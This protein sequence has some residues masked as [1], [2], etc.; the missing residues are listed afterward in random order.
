MQSFYFLTCYFSITEQPWGYLQ[1]STISENR[2][3]G[4]LGLVNCLS[5]H[6]I[7][8]HI[9][10]TY[11]IF[12]PVIP[13]W[14]T[15]SRKKLSLVLVA[16]PLW[17]FIVILSGYLVGMMDWE[18]YFYIIQVEQTCSETIWGGWWEGAEIGSIHSEANHVEENQTYH[19][20][21]WQVSILVKAL[22]LFL[23]LLPITCHFLQ[24]YYC[25]SSSWSSDNLLWA[26]W[27][28]K[29]LLWGTI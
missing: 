27:S 6:V 13:H 23:Y 9:I 1:S 18:D 5:L 10:Y 22:V 24:A 29:R 20:S 11:V 28:W 21:R 3:L 17:N 2:A 8:L 4:S 16:S 19:G 7:H 15:L 25:S 26:Q 14:S 12:F